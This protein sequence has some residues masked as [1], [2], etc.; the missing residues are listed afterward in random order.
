MTF[1][2]NKLSPMPWTKER[3]TN[4]DRERPIAI[5]TM[6]GKCHCTVLC[7]LNITLSW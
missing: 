2:Y 4:V 1:N 7:T 3:K 6:F 5:F